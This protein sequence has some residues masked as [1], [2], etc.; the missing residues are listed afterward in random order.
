MRYRQGGD[1]NT[2]VGFGSR[3]DSAMLLTIPIHKTL[4]QGRAEHAIYTDEDLLCIQNM[5]LSPK[6]GQARSLY[7]LNVHSLSTS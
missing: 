1:E 7:R 4:R 6:L 5:Y 3:K 2:W